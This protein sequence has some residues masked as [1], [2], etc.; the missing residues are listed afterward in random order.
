V[1]LSR[2]G[3]EVKVLA[4]PGFLSEEHFSFHTDLEIDFN[5]EEERFTSRQIT[6]A[7][8]IDERHSRHKT[9]KSSNAKD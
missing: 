9:M 5:R 8:I 1:P 3:T 6:F 7:K 4:S 2:H